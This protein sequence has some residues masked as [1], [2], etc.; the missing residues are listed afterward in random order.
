MSPRREYAIV[1]LVL[2]VSGVALLIAARATWARGTET[3]GTGAVINLGVAG[4]EFTPWVVAA[5]IVVVAMALAVLISGR[6]ARIVAGA[7]ALCA[8]L[9]AAL[10]SGRVALGVAQSAIFAGREVSVTATP[11]GWIS[12][13]IGI[14]A[15]AAGLTVI[16]RCNRWPT[17]S[18][19][20]ERGDKGPRDAW[21]ALDRGIDPTV[22]S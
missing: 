10:I 8:G 18:S 3:L 22:D 2:A 12:A 21:E 14:A 6:V 15:A 5:G 1:W 11:W 20:Y 7:A 4:A 13:V 16:V 9:G 17:F 19:R